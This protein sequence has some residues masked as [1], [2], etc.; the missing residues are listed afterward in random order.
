[1]KETIQNI[2]KPKKKMWQKFFEITKNKIFPAIPAKTP[3]HWTTIFYK[4]YARLP[5]FK[6]PPPSSL[7]S[8]SLKRALQNRKSV[9]AFSKACL[10]LQ[11]LSTILYY[12]AGIRNPSEKDPNK[13]RR[14]YP[15]GG[16]RYPLEIYLFVQSVA[17]L[18][19]GIYHYYVRE[20]LL[21]FISRYPSHT[22][23]V[24]SY[25]FVS[26]VP[27]ILAISAFFERS[28][29]KYGARGYNYSLLEAGHLAQNIYLT[30]AALGKASCAIGG[31]KEDE[32]NRLLDLDTQDES[33]IYTIILGK[34]T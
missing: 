12:S 5:A 16:A 20:H 3:S 14:F 26:K 24:F 22:K 32:L 29:I 19:K 31:F 7:K 10:S 2:I 8:Q 23:D 15:S 27:C 30:V 4:S 1:M 34:N 28:A 13:L 21:E 11:D 9:R 18:R 6:L 33:V 17:G 25:D